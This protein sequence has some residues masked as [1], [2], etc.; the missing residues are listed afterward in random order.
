LDLGEAAR[1][2]RPPLRSC[3]ST[4][5]ATPDGLFGVLTAYSTQ[6]DAFTEN[7]QRILEAVAGQAAQT[8]KDSVSY[9]IQAER[10]PQRQSAAMSDDE[11]LANLIM[12][13]LGGQPFQIGFAI[14]Q[15][16]F[17]PLGRPAVPTDATSVILDAIRAELRNGDRLLRAGEQDFIV[18][19][20]NTNADT[21]LEMAAR[22]RERLPLVAARKGVPIKVVVGVASAPAD[23]VAL[24]VLIDKA[25]HRAIDSGMGDRPGSVH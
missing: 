19:L 12:T 5:I 20:P 24:S 10:R 6:R 2:M 22:I 14:I 21:A 17:R 25:K 18:L 3:L 13:E 7:H 4:P 9:H 1:S 16:D 23:G 15:V 8:L 11:H